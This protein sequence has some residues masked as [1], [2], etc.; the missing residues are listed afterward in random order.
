M[1]TNLVATD[2]AAFLPIGSLDAYIHHV[3]QVPMLTDEEEQ[4]LAKRLH[5]N[6][7]LEAAKRLVMSHL[8]FVVRV[9]RSYAG[10]GLPEAD[11]I[12]EGN[13]G[14]LK[15]VKRFNPEVG[16]RLVSFAIHWIKA[17]MHEYILAN[18]RIVKVATTK[19]QRKLFF[20]LRRATKRLKWFSNS[21]IDEVATQ[22]NVNP[23]EVR[24]MEMRLMGAPDESL[25]GGSDSGDEGSTGHFAPAHYL[26]DNRYNP[27]Q[28]LEAEDSSNQHEDS[29]RQA[30]AQLNARDRDIIEQRWLSDK[31]TTLEV[32]AEKYAVSAERIR[33][34]EKN[35]INALRTLLS[36]QQ[37]SFTE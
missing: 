21:E 5:E 3:N 36:T 34:L 24:R 37:L 22:L 14:L 19:A 2:M 6:G 4:T 13:I 32:L 25:E 33:Q 35:A 9:A 20:N 1:N 11:L 7:D 26:E 28:L 18:W 15:A 27:A 23:E 8:R 16:V 10:Y 29:L 31:K 17:E 30:I 12:Q